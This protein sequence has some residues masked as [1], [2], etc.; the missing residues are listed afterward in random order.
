MEERDSAAGGNVSS[1]GFLGLSGDDG[2]SLPSPLII[3]SV[4]EPDNPKGLPMATICSPILKDVES[5]IGNGMSLYEGMLS[6]STFNT[7]RSENGSPPI[8]LA[9]YTV[10]SRNVICTFPSALLPATT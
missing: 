3:P 10:P 1:D 6:P 7:A 9:L 4:I 5:P 2:I 8:N